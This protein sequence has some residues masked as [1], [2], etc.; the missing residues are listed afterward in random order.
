MEEFDLRNMGDIIKF[1]NHVRDLENPEFFSCSYA[2]VIKDAK[3]S[4]DV[5]TLVEVDGSSIL[6]TYGFR[7]RDLVCS[8]FPLDGQT[9]LCEIDQQTCLL[10]CRSRLELRCKLGYLIEF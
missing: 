1:Y 10:D 8:Q 6:K 7:K 2:K 4:F 3:E 5:K 9:P